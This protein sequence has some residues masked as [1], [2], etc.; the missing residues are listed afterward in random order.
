MQVKGKDD[1]RTGRGVPTL[2]NSRQKPRVLT[3]APTQGGRA[4]AR[5]RGR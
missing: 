3:G 5:G 4:G 2:N 1:N